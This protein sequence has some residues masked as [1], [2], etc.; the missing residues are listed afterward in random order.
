MPSI[1]TI[2]A[3]LDLVV[4]AG[5]TLGPFDLVITDSDTGAPIDLTGSTL[6]AAVSKLGVSDG[7][8]PM[9]LTVTDA[10]NGKATLKYDATSL[11]APDFFKASDQY[12]WFLKRTDTGGNKSTVLFGSVKVAKKSPT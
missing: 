9:T 4:R 2:G 12:S 10:V 11:D 7:D 5:D 6:E 1:G 3:R 8:L